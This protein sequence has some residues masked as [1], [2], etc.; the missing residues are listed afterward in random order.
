MDLPL[1]WIAIIAFVIIN[2]MLLSA[3]VLVYAER[4]V[5]GFIQERP[6]PNRVGPGGFLQPFADVLKLLMK[7]DITPAGAHGRIH[8]LAPLLMVTISLTVPAVIPFARGVVIADVG[9]GVLVV[10]ALTSVSVYGVA[11]AGWA[12]NSKYSLLGGL[13]AAAQMI[14]YELSMGLAVV[15]VV[16]IAGTLNLTGIVENQA[17]GAAIL[18]WHMFVNP[19]GFIIFVIT[20]FAEANRAPFDLPEA[21]HELVGGFH[22]E[23]SGMKFGMFFLAEYVNFFIASFIIVTLFCGGYL[24]PF[25]PQLL[26]AI[27]A[28]EGS[29]LLGVLQVLS[30]LLKTVFFA[31]LFIWVRWTLPRFRYND[32]MTIGWKVLLPVALANVLLVALG[33]L[34]F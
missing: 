5:A 30:L 33:V 4:K 7:E 18:G 10:L 23:Y 24:V 34:I 28:L 17:G 14:S 1:Y 27:P 6:G 9:M 20:A 3:A 19:F 8:A 25:E 16:L 2:L 12:S 22:T 11:L 21:E 13:R 15:S 31:F 32:L 29:I 26:A